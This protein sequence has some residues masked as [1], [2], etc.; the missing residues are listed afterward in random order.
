MDQP[1]AQLERKQTNRLLY[2]FF[3]VA[4]AVPLLSFAI[5]WLYLNWSGHEIVKADVRKMVLIIWLGTMLALL[6][7]GVD[8]LQRRRRFG[9]WRLFSSGRKQASSKASHREMAG[10][11]EHQKTNRILRELFAVLLIIPV[12]SCMFVAAYF[13]AQGHVL[14]YSE[15][16]TTAMVVWIGTMLCLFRIGRKASRDRLV[17]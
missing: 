2:G 5:A 14:L 10:K 16:K 9:R 11:W 7:K 1:D 15:W 13:F 8:S 4:I 17:F 6:R 3:Y 12:L